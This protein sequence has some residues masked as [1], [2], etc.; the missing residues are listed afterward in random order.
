MTENKEHIFNRFF[1]VKR[2]KYIAEGKSDLEANEIACKELL[3]YQKTAIEMEHYMGILLLPDDDLLEEGMGERRKNIK[4]I[5]AIIDYLAI[6]DKIKQEIKDDTNLLDENEYYIN[7]SI[8]L[9]K[10]I[11][12]YINVFGEI[13]AREK[14]IEEMTEYL[15]NSYSE[16]E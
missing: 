4:V 13:G 1:N 7:L 11:E 6:E 3:V 10:S 15:R 16:E 2:E 9:D 5:K 14:A 8:R 12:S